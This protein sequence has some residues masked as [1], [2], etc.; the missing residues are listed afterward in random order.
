MAKK[1]N[2]YPIIHIEGCQ[3]K[4]LKKAKLLCKLLDEIEKEF[5]IKEVLI[6]FKD[7]FIC[8]D[9]DLT[10]LSNSTDPMEKLVGGVFIK[11]DKI[12]HGKTSV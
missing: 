2:K 3:V 5:G 12:K 7:V 6:S 8:P 4:S 9:I 10:K 1:K 11:L